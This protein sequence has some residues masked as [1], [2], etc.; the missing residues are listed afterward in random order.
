MLAR[1]GWNVFRIMLFGL[2]FYPATL[3][4]GMATPTVTIGWSVAVALPYAIG[5][6]TTLLVDA[7]KHTVTAMLLGSGLSALAVLL[8]GALVFREGVICILMA[9]PLWLLAAAA[10]SGS[11]NTL[12]DAID[13]RHRASASVLIMLPFAALFADANLPPRPESFTVSRT[14]SINASQDEIWPSLLQLDGLEEDEGVW[15]IAQNVLGIPRPASARVVG[16]GVGTTRVARWGQNIRFEESITAW[17]ENDRLAWNFAFP[18]DSIS[19]YT[20]PHIHPDGPNL[21]VATGEYRLTSLPNGRTEVTLETTYA[22]RT[23]VN[24]YASMWGELILGDIQTNILAIVKERA[25][26]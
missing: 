25:E 24:W 19:R 16:V 22:A 11:V 17:L 21:K 5:G 3:L 8:V 23:P 4:V 13:N 2:V 15:N 20:D 18:D 12:R 26:P 7:R 14:I 1:L 9:V 10:G 6:L